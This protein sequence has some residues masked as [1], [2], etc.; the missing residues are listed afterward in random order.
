MQQYIKQTLTSDE[1]LIS[2]I[3]AFLNPGIWLAEAVESVLHQTYGNWELILVDDGSKKEDTAIATAYAGK[4]PERIR[5]I[6]HDGH[7]NKGV[8]ASRNAGI[9]WAAGEYVAFLDADDCWLPEKLAEQ[10]IIFNRFPEVQM[11]CEA[12]VFW[13]SW[14]VSDEKDYIQTIG[15][16]EGVYQPPQLM[17]L[18]YPLGDGQPPCPSG[19]IITRH[20]LQRAGGFEE[21]FSGIY[22]LYEDQAFLSKVYAREVVYIFGNA[23]NMY[24]KRKD[25]MSS[26]ASDENLYKEVRLF[27]LAWLEIYFFKLPSSCREIEILIDDFRRKLSD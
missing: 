18:L 8:T 25:S 15:A 5:Y 19:I 11:I 16:E 1:P 13:Y 6:E 22:Q 26:A 9:L 24:R 17:E 14:Q 4:Y 12:S 20:A 27:Y 7:L 2:V 3:I 21:T 23:N 10:R